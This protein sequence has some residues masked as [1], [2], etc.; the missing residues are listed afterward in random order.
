VTWQ[1]QPSTSTTS[2]VSIPSTTQSRLD[3]VDL[4]VTNLVRD[5]RQYGNYGFM[6]KLQNETIYTSRI[7][8]SSKHSDASKHPKLVV[9]YS[10]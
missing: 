8:C 5:M 10:N 3:L 6:L 2:Q 1:N 9:V 4:D 7:F